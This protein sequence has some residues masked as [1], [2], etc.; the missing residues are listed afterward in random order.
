MNNVIVPIAIELVI[1]IGLVVIW[2]VRSDRRISAAIDARIAWNSVMDA[3]NRGDYATALHTAEGLGISAKPAR[4]V[5]LQQY[6]LYRGTILAQ[7]GR[8]EEA[9][10]SLRRHIALRDE[11]KWKA[12]LLD[13]P[14]EKKRLELAIA[15][16][17]EFL[18][19]ARRFDEARECFRV[20]M[21]HVPESCIGYLGMADSYL[22]GRDDPVEAMRW[23]RL[24]IAQA[25]IDPFPKPGWRRLC[26][27]ESLATL[28]WATAVNSHDASE[29]TLWITEAQTI[30]RDVIHIS[31]KARFHHF[32]GCAYDEL[33]D[34]ENSLKHY[35]ECAR[36]DTQGHWGR[37]ARR[38]LESRG[39]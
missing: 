34:S 26:L 22:I 4:S 28:A 2:L 3:Y 36:T 12:A 23:A 5:Y 7:L 15:G 24:A 8:I 20:S 25:Q 29:V 32:A 37:E 9:E 33:G 16:L 19:K 30:G 10:A 27:A 35:E 1:P 14:Q 17:G 21:Q 38:A 39:Q 6:H 31:N 13:G 11:T 18:L